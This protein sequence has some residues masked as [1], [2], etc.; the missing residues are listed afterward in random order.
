[1]TLPTSLTKGTARR[2]T[3]AAHDQCGD[4]AVQER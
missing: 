3:P 2:E 1:M 4:K